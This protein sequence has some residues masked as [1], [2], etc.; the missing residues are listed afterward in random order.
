MKQTA[1]LLIPAL[2]LA[3]VFAAAPAHAQDEAGPD[4]AAATALIDAGIAEILEEH[5]VPGAATAIVVNGEPIHTEAYGEA[6]VATGAEGAVPFATETA[7]Y[8]GSLA[9]LFTTAAALQ[10]VEDGRLDLDADV[11]EH[12][13]GLEVPDTFPG[14]PVTLRH[15]LTHTSGFEDRIVGWSA[16]DA[17]EMPSLADFAAGQLPE[18]LRE[19]GT[20]VTYNNYD[21]ALAGLLVEEASGQSYQDYVAEHVFAPLGMDDTRVVTE[22]PAKG[23]ASAEGYRYADGQVPTEGRIAPPTPAGPGVLTTADDMA[24]FMAALAEGDPAL[25]AGVA[26]QMTTRQFAT[27]DR[28]PGMGFS[29]QEYAGPGD[30]IWFK[31]GD[32]PGYHTV[33]ALAPEQ[34]IGVHIALNGDGGDA[35]ETIWAA[36]E[37]LRDVMDELGALPSPAALEPVEAVD[38]D[39]YEGEY[40]ATRTSRSDFT[41]I[42][43]VFG[44][45]TVDADG[46]VLTTTGLTFDPTVGER[47]W[48]PVGDGLFQERDGTATIAFTD[49]GLLLS[50]AEPSAS[51]ARVPWYDGALLHMAGL[52]IGAL[53]LAAGFLTLTVTAVVRLARRQPRRPVLRSLNVWTS[54]LLGAAA[55]AVLGLLMAM[56]GDMNLLTQQIL[57]GAPVLTAVLWTALA[58]VGLAALN[59]ILYTAAAIKRQWTAPTAI[60]QGLMAVAGLTFAAVLTAL[61]LTA[62]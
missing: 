40:A 55:L 33:M 53:I 7:Y 24:L 31:D 43:R 8:A 25:G 41:E 19:P 1:S 39:Q 56:V 9:K 2:A 62:L 30:G 49:D 12:L 37:L 32:L 27:D 42:T 54:W 45:V 36:R 6:V 18:R 4:T 15:L 59:A 29:L 61:N 38:L 57:T 5:D 44:P 23:P 21:M 48:V 10:L 51:Y 50:S 13:T 3:G 47:H 34:G 26:E 58:A 35:G 14:E 22:E 46:G 20:L 16:W 52:G 60:G 28:M 17:D 11:N